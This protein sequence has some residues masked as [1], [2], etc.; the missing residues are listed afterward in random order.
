MAVSAYDSGPLTPD[1]AADMLRRNEGL[2]LSPYPDVNHLRVGYGSDTTTDPYGHVREVTSRTRVT[3]T[4]AERDL[5]RREYETQAHVINKIGPDAWMALPSESQTAL[6]DLA[7][8]YG[9]LD[10]LPSIV[11][12]A[13]SGSSEKLAA[14]IAA[15][16]GDNAGV[17]KRRREEEALTVLAGD[18]PAFDIPAAAPKA[19]WSW[20]DLQA[21]PTST[22]AKAAKAPEA[23]KGWSW[24]DLGAPPKTEPEV[25]LTGHDWSWL[26]GFGLKTLTETTP[27][28]GQPPPGD[29]SH[30]PKG[31]PLEE[32]IKREVARIDSDPEL[33]GIVKQ[34]TEEGVLAGP[35]MRMLGLASGTGQAVTGPAAALPNW[36]GGGVAAEAHKALENVGSK[37]FQTMGELSALTAVPLEGI[38]GWA[39]KGL[40][41]AVGVDVAAARAVEAAVP[42]A[43]IAEEAASEVPTISKAAQARAERLAKIHEG[44]V[45]GAKTGGLYGFAEGGDS[46]PEWGERI[47]SK[48]ASAVGGALL[49]YPLGALAPT[50]GGVT[51]FGK[52]KLA[53]WK[54]RGTE[55]RAAREFVSGL[56][57]KMEEHVEGQ[58][59]KLA[60][61]NALEEAYKSMS[62]TQQARLD[63][64]ANIWRQTKDRRLATGASV[65]GEFAERQNLVRD[66]Q[67]RREE[68]IRAGWPA[69]RANEFAVQEAERVTF[70]EDIAD[71]IEAAER[72]RPEMESAAAGERMRLGA[73]H[74]FD[75]LWDTRSEAAGIGKT[76]RAAGSD[77]KYD[78]REVV[79]FVD[80]RLP[81]VGAP[82]ARILEQI[83]HSAMGARAEGAEAAEAAHAAI[84]P[85]ETSSQAAARQAEAQ[86]AR[87]A[88]AKKP[89]RMSLERLE[90]L[91]KEIASAR[92]TKQVVTQNGTVLPV[93]VTTLH[94]L[95]EVSR[96]ITAAIERQ[97][98]ELAAGIRTHAELS[99]G[100]LDEFAASMPDIMAET[101]HGNDYKMGEAV[102]MDRLLSRAKQGHEPIA[103]LVQH[104]RDLQ[105]TM[106]QFFN[107]KL[108]GG[109]ADMPSPKIYENFMLENRNALQ[110]SGLFEEFDELGRQ[111]TAGQ[112]AVAGARRGYEAAER[113]HEERLG[114]HE[115]EVK[116]LRQ[117][118]EKDLKE[119]ADRRETIQRNAQDYEVKLNEVNAHLTGP[120]PQPEKAMLELRGFL[121]NLVKDNVLDTGQHEAMLQQLNEIEHMYQTTRNVTEMVR[122]LG[123][124]VVWTTTATLLSEYLHITHLRSLNVPLPFMG[125]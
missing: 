19:S 93:D 108:K 49:G 86:A 6:T 33:K 106:R 104:D 17:N 38:A 71:K 102:V 97:S 41:T 32:K 5:Q 90:A 58:K 74:L 24:K 4:D 94:E 31:M 76:I 54:G 69:E 98:P 7:Y 110:Q 75:H 56:T 9:S 21:K 96:R 14:A 37:E 48:T 55:D 92:M 115:A 119:L 35:L 73:Q 12:A 117:A 66:I 46:S 1:P 2:R 91:R 59:D 101:I 95:N 51:E 100:P 65:P 36:A 109:R 124:I 18:Q 10:K 82:T 64:V 25:K 22:E 26:P 44:G 43:E 40:E 50:A 53:A 15:R 81:H 113:I 121:K 29:L 85:G 125:K 11:A 84:R 99:R 111:K 13:Q 61:A 68:A 88:E 42:E 107:W 87:Q 122:R 105:N 80:E 72:A 52:E 77:P 78:A 112:A 39:G 28:S 20:K 120:H 23:K 16:A 30:Y 47:A 45:L 118:T 27:S 103:M 83:R 62:K 67:A 57:G 34:K 70:A 8:N 63:E 60:A 114:A 89:G 116:G 123:Q 79:D 3:P